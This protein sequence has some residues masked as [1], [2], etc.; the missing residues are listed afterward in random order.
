MITKVPESRSSFKTYTYPL[1]GTDE[2]FSN[3][4]SQGIRLGIKQNK[5]SIISNNA[6]LNLD[7]EGGDTDHPIEENGEDMEDDD[8]L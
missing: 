3:E 7:V 5:A 6:F 2:L 8:N 1:C 4:D